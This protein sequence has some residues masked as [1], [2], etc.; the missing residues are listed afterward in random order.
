[1]FSFFENI[2]VFRAFRKKKK[3]FHNKNHFEKKQKK[4]FTLLFTFQKTTCLNK[5][6]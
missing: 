4:Q 3:T 1:M 2:Y 6:I 5:K